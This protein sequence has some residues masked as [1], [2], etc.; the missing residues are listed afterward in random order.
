MNSCIQ[1]NHLPDT[2]D[3]NNTQQL[4]AVLSVVMLTTS[5]F[6]TPLTHK[7][8]CTSPCH[9]EL[10]LPSLT[11]FLMVFPN[12]RMTSHEK[13]QPAPYFIFYL[14]FITQIFS[15]SVFSCVLVMHLSSPSPLH[16]SHTADTGFHLP[17]TCQVSKQTPVSLQP[18]R[19]NFGLL[20]FIEKTG[21]GV[22]PLCDCKATPL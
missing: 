6:T 4:F 12:L 9:R 1:P 3:N 2:T 17:S 20:F 13:L 21:L 11:S 15:P 5:I 18:A 19:N 16:P 14:P 22:C 8:S 10:P 7:N